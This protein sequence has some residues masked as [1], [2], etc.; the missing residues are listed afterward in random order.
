MNSRATSLDSLEYRL[1]DVRYQITGARPSAPEVVFV[2]IDDATLGT[3]NA[4]P[5]GRLLLAKLIRQIADSDAHSLVLDVL[6]ADAG[7]VSERASLAAALSQLPTVIAAAARFDEE[8]TAT[9]IW[10]HPAFQAQAEVGLVN[11]Y[12]DAAGT[13]RYFPLFIE[14][15]GAPVPSMPLVAAVKFLNAQAQINDRSVTLGT[16]SVPL[17]EGANMPLRLL[18]PAGSVDTISASTLLGAQSM[19][20]LSG[21]VVVLG[22]SAAGTGDLFATAFDEE[23]P[24]G[25]IIATALSQ[26]IGGPTM[27]RDNSLRRVDVVHAVALTIL[28]LFLMLRLTFVRA[29]PFALALLLT[30]FAGVTLL[31]AQGIWLSAALPLMAALPPMAAAGAMS[32]SKERKTARL[33]E[34]KLESLRRFQSPSLARQIELDPNYLNTPEEQ[35]LVVFFVDITGFT[36]ISQQLGPKETRALLSRFH[37]L[38]DKAVETRSGS[39]INY[40]GDGALAV[41]G[42]EAAPEHQTHADAALEAAQALRRDLPDLALTPHDPNISCRFGLHFGPVILS[43][44]GAE[45][46]QQ[47]SVTGDT[48]NLASRLMEVAKEEQAVIAATTDFSNR[49]SHGLPTQETKTVEIAVRGRRGQVETVL[50]QS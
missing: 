32:L 3:Q 22:Y 27:R 28:G 11:L 19:Q 46:H 31:F 40:M 23:I 7:A 17:D 4:G 26:L 49:L 25:E 39:V 35:E 47:V 2:A 15:D 36:A 37:S 44:L 5:V 38:I 30:S 1:V 50:W 33:S 12:T 29:I 18:G 20:A 43:R 41:F 13:P 14:I 9:V 21:K 6:F 16:L 45:N 8:G 48:V 10:P 42:L 34:R 24:G